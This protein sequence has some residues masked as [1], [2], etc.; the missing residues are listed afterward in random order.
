M[1]ESY[2]AMGERGRHG[3]WAPVSLRLSWMPTT[4]TTTTSHDAGRGQVDVENVMFRR[5]SEARKIGRPFPVV[6]ELL[7]VW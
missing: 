2:F 6:S 1:H 7:W 4:T 3:C 5:L